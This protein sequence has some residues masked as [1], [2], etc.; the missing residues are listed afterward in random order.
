MDDLEKFA[1]TYREQ[2]RGTHYI[3]QGEVSNYRMG[4]VTGVLLYRKGVWQ[5]EMW[6]VPPN[7]IVPEHTHPNVDTYEM[8]LGGD[9]AFSHD[10]YWA[11]EDK[12]IPM[13]DDTQVGTLIRVNSDDKHGGAFGPRGGVFLSLQRWMNGHKPH[14][15]ASDYEGKA[16]NDGHQTSVTY[17]KTSAKGEATW[18]DAATKETSPPYFM[19]Q[20]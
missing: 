14:T 16:F 12:L 5:V 10:G 7:Y 8:Y 11:G 3:P 13:R 9:I 17:G 2:A 19:A 20:G 18:R 15:V 6:I 1:F 4:D